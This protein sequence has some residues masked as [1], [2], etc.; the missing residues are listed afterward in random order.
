MQ[1]R[2]EAVKVRA[3]VA[4]AANAP[5]EVVTLDLAPPAEGE[6]LV[7]INAAGLCHSDLSAME[8][9]IARYSFPIVPGHEGA[10]TVVACGPGVTSVAPGDHVVPVA[11]PECRVCPACTSGRTNACIE[12]RNLPPSRLFWDGTPVPSFCGLGTFADHAVITE[13]RLAKIRPDAPDDIVCYIGCGV[14]TGV[15]AALHTAK[16]SP[17]ST[18]AIVGM[19]G[20]GLSVLQGARI[21]GAT[22]IVCIDTNA[23]REAI[24]RKFGATDFIDP[25]QVPDLGAA[26]QAIVPGGVDFAFEC[27]GHTGLMR[28]MLE[29]TNPGW[30]VGVSVGIPPSGSTLALDPASFMMGRSWKGSLLGGDKTRTAV[31]RLVDWYC[32]GFLKLDE[33]VT[34]RI[35]LDEI[36]HGFDMMKSGEA[37]RTVI[38]FD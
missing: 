13:N 22:R 32:D 24:C 37:I 1:R 14:A 31:P 8:G 2:G 28:T 21:A 5:L 25:A 30:G 38:V 17:G 20:I 15:G 11:I 3:A 12:L 26:I 18:V 4:V 34:H 27:V 33:L 19:G 16:V 23:S 6:V 7:R 36:N 9:K 10:G 35:G 29:A